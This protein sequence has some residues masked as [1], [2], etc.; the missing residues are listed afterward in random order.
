[1]TRWLGR[2]ASSSQILVKP[3]S[4]VSRLGNLSPTLNILEAVC[5]FLFWGNGETRALLQVVLLVDIK[6]FID[7][8]LHRQG[9]MTNDL[10]RCCDVAAHCDT[11]ACGHG[12][13]PVGHPGHPLGWCLM[14]LWFFH[15][16]SLFVRSHLTHLVHVTWVVNC[17][18]EANALLPS[19]FPSFLCAR[20][21]KPTTRTVQPR[22]AT[23][24][25]AACFRPVTHLNP[26]ASVLVPRW[27]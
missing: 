18:K 5:I 8:S 14:I 10:Y 9:N 7:P 12:F 19:F 6:T 25:V 21:H 23:W 24:Q 15:I 16:L 1:M 2:V 27:H 13:T 22:P 20:T 4:W 17:S 3:C 11:L 26:L